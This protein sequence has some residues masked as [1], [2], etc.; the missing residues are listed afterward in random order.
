MPLCNE[1]GKI[2]TFLPKVRFFSCPY[3]PCRKQRKHRKNRFLQHPKE[4][5]S[6]ENNKNR[7]PERESGFH[8]VVWV[9]FQTVTLV[10]T[11]HT[12][13]GVHQLLF[14]GEERMTFGANFNLNVLDGGRS[15]NHIA[16]RTGDGGGLIVGMNI[17]FHVKASFSRLEEMKVG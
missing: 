8:F 1:E 6:S 9:L 13:A 3:P 15:F 14:A 16:A 7:P 10:E 5:K 4:K 2:W 12:T 17:L 11:I